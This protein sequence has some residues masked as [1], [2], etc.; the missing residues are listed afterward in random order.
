MVCITERG[1]R[2]TKFMRPDINASRWGVWFLTILFVGI[3]LTGCGTSGTE[4][5]TDPVSGHP[6]AEGEPA[7]RD[8]GPLP[9]QPEQGAKAEVEIN[10]ESFRFEPAEVT[11]APGTL[12][13][14]T[15]K[16]E[17]PHTATSTDDKFNSGG[18]DTDDR[19]S[20]V[21]KEKGHFPYICALHPH[22][23]AEI[24]VR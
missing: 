19:Y 14:W 11:V 8:S 13:T 9:M 6:I 7:T 2:A 10:I 17:A 4:T 22:M 12:I 16:D 24:K 1:E 23:K 18:L 3:L 21:F 5:Q 15:N 20:F